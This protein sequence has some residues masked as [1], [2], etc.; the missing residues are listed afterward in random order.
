[1]TNVDEYLK[2]FE[3]YR[4]FRPDAT[5]KTDDNGTTHIYMRGFAEVIISRTGGCDM[6]YVNLIPKERI[7]HVRLILGG[8]QAA[9]Y[10]AKSPAFLPIFM[11]SVD[12]A[13]SLH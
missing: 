6:P 1:M 3:Q 12:E 8:P 11:L 2:L 4:G 5:V 7:T 9:A 13:R 10:L